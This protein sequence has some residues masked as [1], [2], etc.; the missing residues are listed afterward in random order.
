MREVI[1]SVGIDIGTSTTQLI[2]S[3]FVVE[4]IAGTYTVPKIAILD[5]KV[6]YRSNVYFTP[7]KSPTEI[8]AK[9]V[10]DIIR[11]EYKLAGKDPKDLH[12]GAVIITGETAR[13]S[14]AD[15]VLHELSDLAG[16]FVVATAGPD[17]ESVLAARGA[18]ADTFSKDKRTTVCNLDVGG[19]TSNLALYEKGK[20][21]GTCC[22]DIGGRLIKV[23]NGKISYIYGKI[24]KL[25][26]D[27]GIEINV[28]DAVDT[29][30][31]RK[32]CA[33]MADHLAQSLHLEAQT[34]EHAALYTN[35]GR[36]LPSE[37]AVKALTFSGGVADYVYHTA[38]KDLYKYGDIGILLGEAIRENGVLKRVELYQSLETLRATVVGAGTHTTSISGS[39]IS[40]AQERLPL[41]NVPILRVPE[42]DE[43]SL[44]TFSNS[45]RTQLPLFMP[46]GKPEQ[47]AI[48][49]SGYKRTSFV[50]IQEL[51]AAIIKGAQEVI[52]SEY[53]LVIVIEQDIA[54][55]MGH[56]LN[57]QLESKKDIICIDT[58]AAQSGDYIDIGRPVAHGQVVPVVVKTLV[59]NS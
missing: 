10:T 55:A 15:E 26:H 12:T 24:Q 57:V 48:S 8:D 36:P 22:L 50:E 14:N 3:T 54:K 13:K 59:F 5:K 27:H 56:A 37:P 46:E 19:G 21:R 44:D 47:V 20:L 23:E 35:A 18:G 11:N 51:A 1:Q 4:N 29:A 34:A 7:L 33:I 32:I 49:F 9:A 6:T 52:D 25:A 42:E 45:I 43:E 38:D 53:P 16:D 28:G 58:V 40:V 41:K 17:L 2:F 30:K 31:L 39:T